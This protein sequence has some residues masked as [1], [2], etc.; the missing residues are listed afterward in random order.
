MGEVRAGTRARNL[1]GIL[2]TQRTA[3]LPGRLTFWVW[4]INAPCITSL[5]GH[6]QMVTTQ[7]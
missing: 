4:R 5:A 7:P 2:Y 3:D 6:L 1:E